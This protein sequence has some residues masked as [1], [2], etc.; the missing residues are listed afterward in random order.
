MKITCDV[1]RDLAELYVGDALSEDSKKIVEEHI[2]ACEKCKDYIEISKTAFEDMPAMD[3]QKITQEK[4]NIKT[5]KD[6]IVSMLIPVIMMSIIVLT[7]VF[8]SINYVLFEH[9]ILIPYDENAVR[10]TE[11]GLMY[12]PDCYDVTFIWSSSEYVRVEVHT[13]YIDKLRGIESDKESVVDLK[14]VLENQDEKKILYKD[15]FGEQLIWGE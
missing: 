4:A 15:K 2:S 10:V 14:E 5:L 12:Y 13:H 6:K 1:I 11:E 9:E 7:I 8:V 3:H